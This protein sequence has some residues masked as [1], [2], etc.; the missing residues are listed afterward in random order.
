MRGHLGLF[1]EWLLG[2]G[3][4]TRA[5]LQNVVVIWGVSAGRV[6]E[7][8]GNLGG[9]GGTRCGRSLAIEASAA[10]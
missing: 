1:S 9:F 3:G 4:P 5:E 10:V 2:A 7:R 6:A 8:G